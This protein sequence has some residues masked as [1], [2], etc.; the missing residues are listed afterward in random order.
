MAIITR[1]VLTSVSPLVM[2]KQFFAFF[3]SV[4]E[5]SQI[6]LIPAK[7][8]ANRSV[9]S[10]DAAVLLKGYTLPVSSARQSSPREEKNSSEFSISPLIYDS[11]SVSPS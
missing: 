3:I 5:Y 6:V 8:A 10:T 4:T 7:S 11:N 1:L 9:S 2:I